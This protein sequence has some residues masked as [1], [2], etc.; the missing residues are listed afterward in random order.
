[1]PKFNTWNEYLDG[2]G[3]LVEKPKVDD[4]PDYSGPNPFAPDKGETIGTDV[5]A[6]KYK[7]APYRAPGKPVDSAKGEKGGFAD[8]GDSKLIYNPD[9]T[10]KDGKEISTWPKSKTES[11][12]NKTKGM[13]IPEFVKYMKNN[14]GYHPLDETTPS[15][16][17]Y[18]AGKFYP[19]P[20]EATRYLA[21]ISNKDNNVLENFVHEIKNRNAL[22]KLIETLTEHNEFFDVLADMLE[23]DSKHCRSL[24]R[25]MNRSY[26][27]AVAPPIGL[28][29]LMNKPKIGAPPEGEE[30]ERPTDEL[31]N[32]EEGGEEDM[33][34]EEDM[35]GEEGDEGEGNEMGDEAPEDEENTDLSSPPK[36]FGHDNMIDAM[37][38]Y[39][40]MLSKMKSV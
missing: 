8:S 24:A 5:K 17:A 13:E 15:V 2:R 19:N 9:T 35:G 21:A 28:D 26:Q 25:S 39:H 34:D 40:Q 11:F 10:V 33:G 12:H 6:N 3:K 36:K 20:H 29:K 30:E 23:S 18:N 14:C 37:K 32:D 7:P 1:M 16:T 4:V 27:E 22:H 38:N 31:P